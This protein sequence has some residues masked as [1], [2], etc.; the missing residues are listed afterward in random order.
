MTRDFAI[1]LYKGNK[2]AE[3]IYNAYDIQFKILETKSENIF[4]NT[5]V[6][7]A[8]EIGLAKFERILKIIPDI[9]DTLDF[10]RGRI[11]NRLSQQSP[12]TEVWLRQTLANI[13]GENNYIVNVDVENYVVYIDVLTK[14]GNLFEQTMLDM[15]QIIPANMIL[16]TSETVQYTH[17]YLNI[18]YTHQEMQ[19]FTQGE[20][21]QYN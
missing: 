18:N 20:L 5:F 1:D 9:N 10:R 4:F 3:A 7:T 2:S 11:I 16:K 13:F 12:F 19:Q 14:T 8:N 6:I 17:R 21:S 15:R